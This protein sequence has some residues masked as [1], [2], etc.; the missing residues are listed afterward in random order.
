MKVIIVDSNAVGHRAKHSMHG[1]SFDEMQTGVI[2][3]FMQE[4]MRLAIRFET[5]RFIFCWDSKKN[6]RKGMDSNYKLKR[7]EKR[8]E[9][10]KSEQFL[11]QTA[12]EQFHI[13]R[14]EVLPEFGFKN[15]LI[16]TG[17]EADDLIA[18]IVMNNDLDMVIAS[19]DEDLYQLL[20]HAPMYSF[21]KKKLYTK[22]DFK[23]DYGIDVNE[24]VMVKAIAGCNS[25]NVI[26]LRGVGEKTA[27]KYLN[28]E[29]KKEATVD[30]IDNSKKMIRDNLKLVTLP[31]FMEKE[32]KVI[33]VDFKNEEFL[34]SDFLSICDKYGFYSLKRGINDWNRVFKMK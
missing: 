12:Y 28:G 27:I 9:K 29:L 10:T 1:L 14:T 24:W 16:K 30:S 2:F 13:L 17:Y 34:I 18:N 5:N 22:E 7:E 21:K 20:N 19:S 3:G 25:D 11:D 26:G 15:N 23:K 31:L 6:F 4:V 33:K 32:M 8:K